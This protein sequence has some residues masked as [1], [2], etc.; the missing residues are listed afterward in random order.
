MIKL[1]ILFVT[2]SFAF[3]QLEEGNTCR[4]QTILVKPYES[5]HISEI[6]ELTV[7]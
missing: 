5:N 1:T 6:N 7:S 3:A 4:I 2:A